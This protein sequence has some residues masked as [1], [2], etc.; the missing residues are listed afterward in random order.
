LP[1]PFELPVFY[2]P[3][4]ARLNPG[5]ETAR[6]HTKRWAYETGILGPPGDAETPEVWSESAFDAMDYA[7]LC[8]YT[9]PDAPAREL[10]LVTDWY[11]WVFYFDD[12]FLEVF[13]RTRDM[14]G[15]RRYLAR[16]SAFMPPEPDRD[17]MPEP[18][19]PVERGLADLWSRTAPGMD[20]DWRERFTADTLDLLEES[21]WELSNIDEG[22]VPN[23]IEY[24]QTR[25]RVGGA[26]WSAGLVEYATHAP[27]PRQ[28]SRTR[29]LGVLKDAFSDGV[30]LRNDI[31]SYQRES[32]EEGEINNAVLVL[33]RFLGCG[34]QEAAER[35]NDLITS[36]LHQFEHTA[37][38]ELP[39]LFEEYALDPAERARVLAYVKGLQDWQAGG[40]EWHLRSSRYMN[41]GTRG[42]APSGRFSAGPR[43]IGTSAARIPVSLRNEAAAEASRR[44]RAV[45][46]TARPVPAYRVPE[47]ASAFPVRI[48]PHVDEAREHARTWA[49]ATGLVGA[50]GPWDAA[51]FDA[52][53]FGLFTAL[54]NPAASR[55]QLKSALEWDVWAWAMDDHL[56]DAFKKRQ[57]YAGLRMYAEYVRELMPL[58]GG[59]GS[60]QAPSGPVERALAEV[61]AR[62][63][64]S[65]GPA[66]RRRLRDSCCA[67]VDSALWE[68]ANTLHK[69]IPDPVDYVEMRRS[70]ATGELG[71]E[72]CR[73]A[74]GRGLPD[75]LREHRSVCRLR[76]AAAD[77]RGLCNDIYSYRKEI[78]QE[79]EINNAVAVVQDFLDCS[80]QDAVDI[81][82]DLIDLRTREF[83]RVVG[84][85][86]PAVTEEFALPDR[87]RARLRAYVASLEERLAGGLAWYRGDPPR[88]PAT[89]RYT[90]ARRTYPKIRTAGGL[91]G[92]TGLGTAGARPSRTL[93]GRGQ[94]N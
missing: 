90:V 85:E 3:Y 26:P 23:P 57:D 53:E 75:A 86:L 9:H 50:E 42:Q 27:V 71:A 16:L 24:I 10:N 68:L 76:E 81:A 5:L 61:W 93:A 22:R 70:A 65:L 67:F 82:G 49:H 91:A 32:E 30:H 92:P 60:G 58:D 13:K 55:G 4:P 64:P 48:S 78:E 94:V 72:Y 59:H 37:L 39:P 89:G 7:L 44:G 29:P 15:A 52:C 69:R 43:G 20:A 40:H 46:L 73:L 51:Y 36:R 14:A 1:Q 18:V 87:E 47:F 8:A 62:T 83:R 12:H 2:T 56:V 31:F 88:Y 80:V 66:D 6:A 33:H 74:M 25:R 21:I 34:L 79:E 41:E 77:I 63:A 28:V 84:T 45:A 35:V 17:R 54:C 11:V 19:N 38:A